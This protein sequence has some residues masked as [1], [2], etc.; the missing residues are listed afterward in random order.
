MSDLLQTMNS[1]NESNDVLKIQN[2]NV[3]SSISLDTPFLIQGNIYDSNQTVVCQG[4]PICKE[5]TTYEK[6]DEIY[7][8][9]NNYKVRPFYEGSL[10]RVFF[11]RTKWHV[12]T[13]RKLNAF[14]SKWGSVSSFGELFEE[15]LKKDYSTTFDLFCETLCPEYNYYFLFTSEAVFY[16]HPSSTSSLR[17][18]FI[19][20]KSGNLIED[21]I[22]GVSKLD[23]YSLDEIKQKFDK[24]EI[25]GVILENQ[26]ERYCLFSELYDKKKTLYG[27]NKYLAAR[28]LEL[29]DEEK[30]EYIQYFPESVKYFELIHQAKIA[31]CKNVHR[32]YVQ[33]YIQKNF[34]EVDPSMNHFL[35]SLHSSFK[36][37]KK[38]TYYEDV[39]LHFIN[40]THESKFLYLRKYLPKNIGGLIV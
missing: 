35:K 32:V 31:F 33:R 26:N 17:L 3:V 16:I 40:K 28:L 24:N 34:V 36:E 21:D 37:N 38:P 30:K 18:L 29:S 27:N 8:S 9:G 25:L 23:Y 20:D 10:L 2:F 4:I 7:K 39:L 13:S 14:E 5:V 11:H 1:T 6:L 19:K 22:L 12:A 15:Y